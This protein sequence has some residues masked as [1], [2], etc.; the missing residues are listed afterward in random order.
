VKNIRKVIR[1]DEAKCDGC[2]QCAEA[3]AE[4]AIRIVDGKARLVSETYCDGL[5]ACIGECPQGAIA[6][7]EREAADFDPEAVRRHLEASGAKRAAPSAPAAHGAARHGPAP[8]FGG[9]PGSAVRV[10]EPRAEAGAEAPDTGSSGLPSQLRNWPVQIAL[11]PVRA[12]FYDGAEL[13]VA[14]DCAPFAFADFHRR[15]LSGRV[16]AVGCPKLDDTGFYRSKLGR[17]LEANDVRSV[18]VVNMEVPCCFG[19]VQLARRAIV[20][21]G[22]SIPLTV[23]TIGIRGDV[24][25]TERVDTEPAA[26]ACG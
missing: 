22:K 4:G 20:E 23:T 5:G 8:H 11:L 12:P 15:F 2:G 18:H 3:C 25:G 19:L 9:C 6:V 21:S 26:E 7:E 10:F 24:L 17:I 14:A 13:L 1:I 16:L